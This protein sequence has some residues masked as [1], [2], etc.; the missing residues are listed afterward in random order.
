MNCLFY[1]EKYEADKKHYEVS[2]SLFSC[3]PA[4]SLVGLVEIMFNLSYIQI[5]SP[6]RAVNKLHI[7]CNKTGNASINETLRIVGV[8]TAA[9]EKP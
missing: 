9:V 3:V 4:M 7:S 6:Y 1:L 2:R 8:T 5:I